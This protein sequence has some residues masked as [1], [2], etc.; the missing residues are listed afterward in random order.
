MGWK[1]LELR[2]WLIQTAITII[3]LIAILL[4]IYGCKPKIEVLPIGDETYPLEQLE[5]GTY[6][7]SQGY[8]I[9]HVKLM[10]KV[11]ILEAEL[12]ECQDKLK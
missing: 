8:V 2:N 10:A 6:R 5:D 9:Y 7:V 1:Q 12:E 3:I 4:L 11:K